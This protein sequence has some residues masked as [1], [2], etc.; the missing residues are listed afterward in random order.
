MKSIGGEA[1]APNEVF[2]MNRKFNMLKLIAS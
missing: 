2:S 1:R